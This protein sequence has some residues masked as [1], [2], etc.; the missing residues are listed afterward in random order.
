MRMSL[1][2]VNGRLSRVNWLFRQTAQAIHEAA[3]SIISLYQ[4]ALADKQMVSRRNKFLEQ[5]QSTVD[6][7][8][9]KAEKSAAEKI[10]GAEEKAAEALREQSEAAKNQESQLNEKLRQAAKII[11]QRDQTIRHIMGDLK[12]LLSENNRLKSIERQWLD[13]VQENK[14]AEMMRQEKESALA[15]KTKSAP[16]PEKE[17]QP[18]SSISQASPPRNRGQG[19]SR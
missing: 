12:N 10:R 17:S 6:E 9:A 3:T 11:S 13:Q 5:S 8:I 1:E 16:S 14:I 19:M 7:Q 15:L 2:E 18:A 4:Q